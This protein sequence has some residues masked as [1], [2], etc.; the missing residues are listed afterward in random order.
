MNQAKDQQTYINR[1]RVHAR[2]R[3]IRTFATICAISTLW[4]T[5]HYAVG[6]SRIMNGAFGA[7][8]GAI[9]GNFMANEI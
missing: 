8:I 4:L 1:D 3:R 5:I 6:S 7:L 2:A 9:L